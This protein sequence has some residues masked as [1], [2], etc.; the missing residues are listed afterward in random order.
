VLVVDASA[1]ARY[2]LRLQLRALGAS[3][4]QARSVEQALPIL[5]EQRPDLIITAPVL[6]GM[7]A[8]E[9]AALL[10]VRCG[11]HAPPMVIHCATSRWP[12]ADA[13]EVH[14]ATAVLDSTELQQRLPVLLQDALESDRVPPPAP[15]PVTRTGPVRAQA[16]VARD[17]AITVAD[18]QRADA[19]HPCRRPVAVAA[20]LGVVI[21]IGS[22]WILWL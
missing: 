1:P 16:P 9:L 13:T 14:G 2:A 6:P 19:T 7:N 3:V 8:L 18:P 17:A 10:R 4:R 5:D 15:A 12:L 22:A 11:D 20:L 21:G